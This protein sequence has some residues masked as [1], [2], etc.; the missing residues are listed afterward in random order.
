MTPD[1]EMKAETTTFCVS[2][3]NK[4]ARLLLESHLNQI[5]VEGEI[6]NFSRPSSGHWYFSL[7]DEKAQIRCAMFRNRNV[8][9]K[10][11]PKSGDKVTLRGRI[12]LYEPRGDYQLIA[13]HME[14]SGAGLLQ[15]QFEDLKNKLRVEGLFD[16]L[17]KQPIPAHVKHVAI[18]SSPSGAAVH[19]ILNVLKRRNPSIAVTL[20]PSTVQGIDAPT[21]LLKGMHHAQRLDNPADLIIIGRGGGSIEDLAA[22]NNEALARAIFACPLPVVSAVGH[23]TDVSISDFVAD[24]RAPTPSAAAELVSG[25]TEEIKQRIQALYSRAQ[26]AISNAF[27]KH[28]MRTT[29]FAKRLKHPGEKISHWQQRTDVCEQRL[30]KSMQQRLHLARENLLRFDGHI[31]SRQLTRDLHTQKQHVDQLLIRLTVAISHILSSKKSGLAQSAA[32]LDIV[33]PLA[34]LKR[35]YSITRN[36]QR[37]VVRSIKQI[38]VGQCITVQIADGELKADTIT[39]TPQIT[40]ET[41]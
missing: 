11:P 31:S 20:I 35:G 10:K 17:L 33:S 4:Q 30:V 29:E 7:K 34:T 24:V 18:I 38:E 12:S 21:N 5:W 8:L 1:I 22:F 26:V 9:V 40:S 2:D 39:I 6:S 13:E 32:S 36:E 27:D 14:A 37:K 23:E 25:D 3:L 19:D 15:R 41:K 16:S 28:A